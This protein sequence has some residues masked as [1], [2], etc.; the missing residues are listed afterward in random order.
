MPTQPPPG[1]RRPEL[2]PAQRARLEARLAGGPRQ[3]A[4]PRRPPGDAAP[5]S[6]AQERLYFVDRLQH[7]G[8][9]Y[10]VPAALRLPAGTD[11]GAL[12]RALGEVVRRHEALRTTFHERDGVPVQ[13]VAPF[14]GF[15]LPVEDLSAL[16]PGPGAA[17]VRQ[18]AAE[19]AARPFDLAAGP[20]FRARLL[21]LGGGEQVLLLCM[22]HIVSDGWSMGVLARELRV[23]YAAFREGRGSPLAALP[24]QYADFA[25]WQRGRAG[26]EA[27]ARHLA[28]WTRQLA[29]APELLE[30]PADRPRPAVPSFRGAAVPVAL[31]PEL[32]ERL[33]GLAR[34]QGATLFMVV[35]AAFQALL[36]RYGAGDDVVVGTP[37]AGR[38][39]AELEGLI[40]FFVNTLVLCTELGGDPAFRQVLARVREGVLGAWE[41]Q[42]LPFERLVAELRP[43]RTLSHAPLF[44]VTFSLQNADAADPG[45][46]G[47]DAVEVEPET[48]K[49]DLSLALTATAGGGVRG[50]LG[51]GTDLFDRGTAERMAA[52]LGRVLEQAAADPGRRLAALSL[53]TPAERAALVAGWRRGGTEAGVGAGVGAAERSLH[54]RFEAQAARAPGAVAATCDGES[55]TYAQLDARADRIARHLVGR[56]VGAEVRVGVCLGRSL[57]LVAAVLG[58]LKA[59]GAYVPID[60]AY[61]AERIAYLLRDSGVALVLAETATRGAAAEAPVPVLL[62]GD[63]L[64][65]GSADGAPLPADA[66]PARAAYVIYTSGSTGRPKGVVVT[67]ACVLRLFRATDAWFG[68][69]AGDVW[70]LFHSCAFDFSVWEIWGALL[71][72]GRLVVVPFA[73]TRDPAA[74]RAL[75]ARE[76]VTVLSQTPSAFRQLL[77][78]DEEANDA[79]AL[80]WVVFGG[81]ALEPRSLR[82]WFDRHG[83]ARPVLVNLYGITE[84]TVHVTYRPVTARDAESAPGS[85]IGAPIP[86]LGVYVLDGRLEPV[87]PGVPGELFV[88]GAGVARGYLGRPALTAER[89]VPD[90]FS[91]AAGARMYRSGDRARLRGGDTE[92]LGRTDQQ[93]KVRG[94]RI[95]PGEV[96]AAL[97]A[98]PGVREAVVLARE[99]EPGSRRLVAYVVAAGADAPDAAALRAVVAARLPE[100]MVPAAFVPLG[101]VPLTPH[102]KVDR[103]ALPAP[104]AA[105]AAA[106]SYVAPR[107]PVE[108]A[109]AEVW[110]RTLGVERVGA[111]DNYFALGGDSMRAL[112]LLAAARAAGVPF[113]LQDLFRHQS[114]AELAACIRPAEDEAGP[115]AAPFALLA[116]GDRE[117]VPDDVEDAYPA[118][119]LQLGMLFHSARSGAEAVYH[120]V[121]TFRVHAPFDP[122]R[123][124]DALDRLAARHPVLR[125]SFD[126]DGLSEPLQR[127]HRTARIPLEVTALDGLAPDEQ[128]AAVDA[129]MRAER[130]RPFDWRAAPLLR[131]HVHTLG[132]GAFHVG[133][134]EHHAILDGW[135]VA[136]LL[137]ELFRLV[138]H[139]GEPLDDAP[140]ASA[141]RDFAALERRVLASAEA[142]AFWARALDGATPVLPAPA[143]AGDGAGTRSL[144]AMLPAA[145]AAR[146][147]RLARAEGLPLKSLLLGAHLRVLA[148]A[149]GTADVTTGLVVNGRPED[150]GA[151]RALGL[152]LNTVPLRLRLDGGSWVELARAAFAAER[153]ILP[154]RRFPV[155]ELQRMRGGDPPFAAL[156][157]FVHFHVLDGM[158]AAGGPRVDGARGRGATSVP[159]AVSFEVASGGVRWSMQCDAARY[160]GAAAERIRGR[161]LAVL[162]RMADDPRGRYEAADLL[163]AAERAA[164]LA[165]PAPAAGPGGAE[166]LDALFTAQAARTP[167]ATALVCGERTL[168]YAELDARAERLARRLR[169]RGVGPEARVALCCRRSPELVVGV[170]AVLRAGGACVPLDPAYP[171]GRLAFILRDAG[172]RLLL[173]DAATAGACG[174]FAGETLLLDGMPEDGGDV[175]GVRPGAVHPRSAAYVVYTSGSTGTP[176]GVVV[177]HAAAAAHLAAFARVLRISPADRV[178]HSA[179]AGF[180][181]FFEQLFLPLAAGAAVVLREGEPW[182]PAAWAARAAGLGVTVANLPPAYWGEVAAAGGALPGLR[183]MLVGADAMPSAAVRGWREAVDTPARLLNAYGPTEAVV[184]ATAYEVGAGYP[185]AHAGPV[186]PI[187]GA[188]PGRGAYVLDPFGAPA[189]PGVPGELCLGGA[190]LARGYAG[191]PGLTAERFVPDPFSPRPGGRMYRTG[192]RVRRRDDGVLEFLGRL[193]AQVKVRGYRIEPG[194]VE[195]ALAAHPAV[196]EAAVVARDDGAGG[197]RLVAYVTAAPGSGAPSAGELRTHLRARLPEHLVPS[198][199]V[200][201]DALPLTPHGKLDRRALP[202]PGPAHGQ[203]ASVAPRDALELRLAQLWEALLGVRPVGVRD[204]F[205]ALGGHS[206]LALRLLAS[207]ERMAG[208]RLPLAALLSAPTVE[209]L[210]RALRAEA[211]PPASGALVPVQ[212]AGGARPLFFVHAA[213]GGV[214]AYAALARHLGPGQPFYALQARGL[215]GEAPPRLRVEEMAADYLAQLRTVQPGGPYRLGGWSMGGLVAFEMA[216]LLQARGEAVELLALVDPPAPGAEAAAAPD[217]VALLAGFVMH[218]GLAPERI[219]LSREQAAALAPARRLER[220]WEAVRA[221]DLVPDDLELARFEAL[222]TV[223]RANAA[224]A[225]AYR[226]APGASDLLLVLAEERAAPAAVQTER[227]KA[228]TTGAVRSVVLPGTH[229]TLVREPHVA[230]LAASLADRLASIS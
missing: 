10:N 154:F 230:A 13:V 93:V 55:L 115:A 14:A 11:A 63:L 72:G 160:S 220:A 84:T 198:A 23:L 164:V 20:L 219:P 128:E 33:R 52:H 39:H 182:S 184:T 54:R 130:L 17:R 18:R 74:F 226:P 142:R 157:N 224:A 158:Q 165:P 113:S 60:P 186:V 37:I 133:F 78:A 138:F 68:F 185:D 148:S 103:R 187:G 159:F 150:A 99:D 172:A 97:L 77:R 135:S 30:L 53:L 94:F 144:A 119:Q 110:A 197:R 131:F 118:T 229:F 7:A 69:G 204:D 222:W 211:A 151:E 31:P 152:F 108:A 34:A 95:E 134:T 162:E 163:S 1:V 51:Y 175:E 126:L 122:A 145:L 86:D 104:E 207:V 153:R 180:D 66:D 49:Y 146:L 167:G 191:R 139:P 210:A 132:P 200:A 57:E 181:V 21:R 29:G 221:A 28:Y 228:L 183:L 48:A 143:P 190:L 22:H 213:G 203:A 201:L 117:R 127:V 169:A 194:E 107:G 3:P 19:D 56:G 62:V 227:W 214:A 208:R 116:D 32:A 193:D 79:L 196:R 87:P 9:A 12:E 67:H 85:M 100:H 89:F 40:G 156:F 47:A 202:A 105:H 88:G 121:Q 155:A 120:N 6:F 176:K 124:R 109:L 59:G 206:L 70:T 102:G 199:F 25:V 106:A 215:E 170:L 43:G 90:P 36:A 174:A 8:A 92:Y 2:T 96:E 189:A 4:I 125:T 98:H 179:A 209:Q 223:F 46:A 15:V 168:G 166:T 35:L 80:R 195:A 38:T 171:A 225:A 147:G 140:P 218:L 81:E 58:V 82:P 27:L 41:H 149:A 45:A 177:E 212:P 217:E 44:Q 129:W 26:E 73:V 75:L 101:A 76:A 83:D 178:L 16:A 65:D 123:L 188:L 136:A 173:A 114:V 5:L 141:P 137:A 205:F 24:V 71:Y 112:Q 50:S 61:P 161:Y 216:R 192:D 64:A 91:G 42:E 111:H